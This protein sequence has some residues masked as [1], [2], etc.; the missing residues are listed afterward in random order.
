MDENYALASFLERI[1][2][3][4]FYKVEYI[5]RGWR[6]IKEQNIDVADFDKEYDEREAL[7]MKALQK[8]S[9]NIGAAIHWFHLSGLTK[10]TIFGIAMQLGELSN[11]LSGKFDG[12]LLN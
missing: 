8:G 1:V 11:D 3:E 7:K 6:F 12:F 5:D 4:N 2:R 10:K 9:N